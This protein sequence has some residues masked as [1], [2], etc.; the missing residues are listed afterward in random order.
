MHKVDRVNKFLFNGR[1]IY[2]KVL[3][4]VGIGKIGTRVANIAKAFNMKVMAYDPYL[5][6]KEI[7]A[8][9]AFKVTWE[10]IFYSFFIT[11]HCPRNKETTNMIDYNV[12]S[13]MKKGASFMNTSRGGILIEDDLALILSNNMIAGVGL[14]VWSEN[15]LQ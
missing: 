5:S 11:V 8:R 1:D 12:L 10:Y 13:L 7:S 9:G 3:G 2:E 6:A 14:D 15:Q 4:I